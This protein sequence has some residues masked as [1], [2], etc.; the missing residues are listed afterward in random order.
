MKAALR[1]PEH[2]SYKNHRNQVWTQ[3]LL[4]VLLAALVFIAVIILTSIA[5]FRNDGDVGRWAAISTI[6]LV[7]PVMIAGLVFFVLLI[8][9]IYL[10]A[11]INKLIPPYSYQG[12]RIAHQIEGS[13]RRIAEMARKPLLVFQ[14]L[15]T[16]IRTAIAKSQERM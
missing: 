5:A 2:P 6:W 7:I 12:Q 16:L 4:P 11:R 1:R 8:A 3:I 9:M 15:G 10:L 14:E 13:A